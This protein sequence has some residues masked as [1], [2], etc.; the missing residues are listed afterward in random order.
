LN[1]KIAFIRVFFN[2]NQGDRSNSRQFI[3][4][5]SISPSVS[6]YSSKFQ[7]KDSKNEF[8][9]LDKSPNSKKFIMEDINDVEDQKTSGGFKLQNKS[10]LKN[11][12]NNIT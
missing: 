4:K 7:K 1:Q 6:S 10:S 5:D 11:S 3:S 8:A 12:K 9:F 2:S